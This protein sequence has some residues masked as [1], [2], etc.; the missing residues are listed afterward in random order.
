MVNLRTLSK[1][2]LISE[3]G[4]AKELLTLLKTE[5]FNLILLDISKDSRAAFLPRIR[6]NDKNC[7]KEKA[8]GYRG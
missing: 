6:H 1:V 7:E 2:D 8:Q 4:N 3:A 5:Y